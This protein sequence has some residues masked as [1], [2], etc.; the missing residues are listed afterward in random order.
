MNRSIVR[1]DAV[2]EFVQHWL[3]V[4]VAI[5]QGCHGGPFSPV[6][7]VEDGITVQAVECGAKSLA[8]GGREASAGP[9]DLQIQVKLR[10]GIKGSKAHVHITCA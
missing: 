4:V 8:Q 1:L 3:T 10:F 7:F 6:A 2:S 5:G 9:V